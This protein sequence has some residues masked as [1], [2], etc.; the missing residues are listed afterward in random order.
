[1]ILKEMKGSKSIKERE[2]ILKKCEA[3]FCV[4]EFI[5]KKFLE[6]ISIKIFKKF[7]FCIMVLK[8]K[9]KKFPKKKKEVL[10]VGRLVPEKGVHLY[11][12]VIKI[13]CSKIS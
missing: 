2:N 8:E 3:I 12:D 7:M 4:S 10:F 13:N 5:K 11:V 6:G 1:M 9:L